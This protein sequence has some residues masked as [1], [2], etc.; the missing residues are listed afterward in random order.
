[1][2]IRFIVWFGLVAVAQMVSSL[3]IRKFS[4]LNRM[5]GEAWHRMP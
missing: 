1:M 2:S 3:Q 5:L 4:K